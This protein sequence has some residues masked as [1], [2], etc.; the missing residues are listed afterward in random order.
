MKLR[1]RHRDPPAGGM[2][3]GRW[4]GSALAALLLLAVAASPHAIAAQPLTSD[5]YFATR[6]EGMW[7]SSELVGVTV[8]GVDGEELGPVV[9]VLVGEP[10][11]IVF[12]IGG[13]L[14]TGEKQIAVPFRLFHIT[15]APT[16][17]PEMGQQAV[18]TRLPPTNSRDPVPG[19]G[20]PGRPLSPVYLSLAVSAED[21]AA[22]PA[23]SADPR[24]IPAIAP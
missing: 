13:F 20:E 21:L 8:Y 24:R 22:A 14:G 2:G 9:E 16:N 4:S 19:S 18:G 7:A 3:I 1:L 17:Q 11:V 10:D 15:A 12:E 5:D 23:Y 6:G